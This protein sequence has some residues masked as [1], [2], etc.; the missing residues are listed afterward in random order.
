MAIRQPSGDVAI[1]VP[2]AQTSAHIDELR[3]TDG[4][5]GIAAEVLAHA[6][7]ASMNHTHSSKQVSDVL[8]RRSG[9]V[10]VS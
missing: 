7:D 10:S 9:G 4:I 6:R 8:P 1:R 5:G 2:L 3:A